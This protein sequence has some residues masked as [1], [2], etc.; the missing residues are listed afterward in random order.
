LPVF[1]IRPLSCSARRTN[2]S[3]S[4]DYPARKPLRKCK[5]TCGFHVQKSGFP[6]GIL[7]FFSHEASAIF[8]AFPAVRRIQ[9]LVRQT[10]GATVVRIR[11]SALRRPVIDLRAHFG[12]LRPWKPTLSASH[13]GPTPRRAKSDFLSVEDNVGT[14]QHAPRRCSRSTGH[15]G[16][17]EKFRIANTRPCR[18]SQLKEPVT[19]RTSVQS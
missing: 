12:I 16:H 1:D 9:I 3:D 5:N 13:S 18:Q 8:V 4:N 14:F 2:C 17:G 6:E 19:R 11:V 10:G 7:P 15:L